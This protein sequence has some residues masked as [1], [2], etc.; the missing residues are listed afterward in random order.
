MAPKIIKIDERIRGT[1]LLL[2]VLSLQSCLFNI[3][4]CRLSKEDKQWLL[5]KDTLYYLYNSTDTVA[6]PVET[7][8]GKG[9]YEYTWGI[10]YGDNNYYGNNS[11]YLLDSTYRVIIW[12]EG[13]VD[14]ILINIQEVNESGPTLF[15]AYKDS[16]PA[17]SILING[18]QYS[19]YFKFINEVEK[20]NIQE[21]YFIKKYGIIKLQINEKEI[22]ELLTKE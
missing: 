7:D 11:F 15:Y 8:F 21:F 14:R 18:I 4:G 2:C 5:D 3:G 17:N 16:V 19:G 9:K 13:C 10:P 20:L 22:L 6:V 1:I 12:A